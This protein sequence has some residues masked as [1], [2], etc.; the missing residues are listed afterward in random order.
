MHTLAASASAKDTWSHPGGKKSR[1]TTKRL[2]QKVNARNRTYSDNFA[3]AFMQIFYE[4]V[5][6]SAHRM[7]GYD[8]V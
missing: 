6:L 1:I 5:A 2:F 7:I 3:I 4:Y 8:Q